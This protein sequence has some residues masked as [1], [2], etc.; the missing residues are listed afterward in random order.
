MNMKNNSLKY[1]KYYDYLLITDGIS[2]KWLDTD[3]SFPIDDTLKEILKRSQELT[4][5]EYENKLLKVL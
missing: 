1:Y 2:Y 4:K 3:F 5:S